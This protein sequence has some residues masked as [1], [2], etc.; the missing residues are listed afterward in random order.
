MVQECVRTARCVAE[1]ELDSYQATLPVTLIAT[2]REEFVTCSRDDSL[3]R[4]RELAMG[5]GFDHLPV[6]EDGVV[7][8]VMD[9]LENA[10]RKNDTTVRDVYRALSGDLLVGAHVSVLDFVRTA[11]SV[12]F[13]FVVTD[14]GI[15]GLVSASDMQKLPARAALFALITQLEMSMA[16]VVRRFYK[17]DDWLKFLTDD[18]K[19]KVEQEMLKARADSNQVDSL[20][21][22]NFCDKVRV[23]VEIARGHGISRKRLEATFKPFEELRNQI[24]HSN[25]F[26]TSRRSIERLSI[27]TREMIE[28]QARLEEWAA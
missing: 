7:V 24:A 5:D 15:S 22:T 16:A 17:G 1:S 25:E 11:D 14:R 4:I 2:P 27:T 3:S 20:L 28:W 8:G 19:A 21:Y 18:R 6:V 13:R 9:V 23:V 10:E 26:A 12:P